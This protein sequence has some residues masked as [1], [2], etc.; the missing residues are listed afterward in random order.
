MRIDSYA[1]VQQLYGN[2][3][4]QT[5]PKETKTAFKDQLQI[6]SVGKDIQIAKTAVQTAPDVREDVVARYKGA[7]KAGTYDVSSDRFAQKL[8]DKYYSTQ[9]GS[10]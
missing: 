5:A 6:S 3:K 10:F 4:V 8:M 9:A 1:K 7:V 2:K